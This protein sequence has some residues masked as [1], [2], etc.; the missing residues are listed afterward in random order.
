MSVPME[1][2][3]QQV[4]V[5]TTQL[6]SF[7]PTWKVSPAYAVQGGPMVGLLGWLKTEGY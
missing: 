4:D 2:K 5:R 7:L 1:N 6:T 3:I